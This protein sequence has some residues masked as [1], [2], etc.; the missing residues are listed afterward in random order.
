M[1]VLGLRGT[2]S[3]TVSGQR[4]ENYREKILELYPNG[5][6]PLTALLSMLKSEKTDDPIFHWFEKKLPGQ[7]LRINNGGGY[8]DAAVAATVDTTSLANGITG[9]YGVRKGMLLLVESTGEI[10]YVS[11]DPSSDTAIAF[12]RAFGTTAAASIADDAWLLIIG[13]VHEEGGALPSAVGF[14]PTEFSNYTQI[15]RSPLYM[16]RTAMR[17]RLRT[18]DQVKQ[19]RREALELLTVQKERM[20]IFGELKASTG[21]KGQPM[22]ATRG[23][24]SHIT[25]NASANIIDAGGALSESEWDGYM[26]QLFRYGSTEKL[27]L[28]GSTALMVLASMAKR[29][30]IQLQ[31]MAKDDAY[32]MDLTKYI[33]PFGT[34]YLKSHPLF[35]EHP[36]HRQNILCVDPANLVERYID[37]ITYLKNRQTAGD[38]AMADEYLNEAGLETHHADT[39]MYIKN[40]TSYAP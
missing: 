32:G 36:V 17:T 21:T 24:V 38:D 25:V 34:L 29:G 6:A 18:G 20:F 12:T 11:A 22:R 28:C 31:A 14:D 9:A 13:S 40:I 35:N 27:G 7:R 15:F 23:L 10:L 19:A 4:P 37:D 39:H 8:N 5:K 16:T 2:G 30:G 3:F 1:P 26:E 33:T